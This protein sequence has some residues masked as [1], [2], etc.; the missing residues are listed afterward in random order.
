MDNGDLHFNQPKTEASRAWI[1]LS[2]RVMT[3]LH[4]QT[5]VQMTAHPDDRLE[6]LVFARRGGTP[7]RQVLDQLQ[8]PGLR[9]KRTRVVGLYTCPPADATVV[10]VDEPGP[11]IPRTF[12]PAPGWSPD[13]HR[14][15][16]ELNYGR[17]PER[18]GSTTACAS[19]ADSR[20]P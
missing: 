10:C 3:A 9:G 16:S 15:K 4:R 1:R 8:G 13:G 7:L 12:P 11:V 18:P 5:T 19:A 2:P 17:G 20:S 6:G 14:I